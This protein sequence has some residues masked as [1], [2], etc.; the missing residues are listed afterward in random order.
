[1]A[2][3]TINTK[4]LK[5]VFGIEIERHG[6]DDFLAFPKRK[7]SLKKDWSD[8]NGLEI[9][10]AEPFFEARSFQLNCILKAEGA[11]IQATKDQFW[12]LYNGLFTEISALGT[13]QLYLASIDKTFTVFYVDQTGVSKIGY[14]GQRMFIRFTLV[15]EETDPTANILKVYLTDDA[16]N[17]L[18]A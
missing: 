18:I 5:T 12:N 13:H 16:G 1:M 10:L 9:D 3:N 11:T 17:F 6:L 15:F 14:E 7:D 8:Q 4:N 2:G